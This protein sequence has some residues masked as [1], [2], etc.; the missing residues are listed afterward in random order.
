MCSR[1][2]VKSAGKKGYYA[3]GRDLER[4]DMSHGDQSPCVARPRIIHQ[5]NIQD[6]N[7][8]SGCGAGPR[9]AQGFFSALP[10]SQP[11]FI[12]LKRNIGDMNVGESPTHLQ[13]IIKNKRIMV[14]IIFEVSEEFINESTNPDNTTAKMKAAD[15][16][17]A[18]KVLFDMIGFG[19]LKKQ[20]VKGKKEFTVTPDKLDEKSTEIYNNEIGNICLLAVFS[21]TDKESKPS[22]EE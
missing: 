18:M 2:F 7:H 11:N 12:N 13:T 3:A 10:A 4:Q 17:R 1:S 9:G 20:V 6:R 15:G 22:D 14:K 8:V 5:L 21:E 16:N 19:Q